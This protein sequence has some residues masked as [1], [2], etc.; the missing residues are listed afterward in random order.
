MSKSDI[1][2]QLQLVNQVQ[3]CLKITDYF[4]SFFA[5]DDKEKGQ[6]LC[7]QFKECQSHDQF[8]D[9]I[10]QKLQQ[11]KLNESSLDAWKNRCMLDLYISNQVY[12]HFNW[13]PDL[14]QELVTEMET[15]IKTQQ[16]LPANVKIMIFY[17]SDSILLPNCQ[18][19]N[20]SNEKLQNVNLCS[21]NVVENIQGYR[22]TMFNINTT[23]N[24]LYLINRILVAR[25]VLFDLINARQYIGNPAYI[26]YNPLDHKFGH[27]LLDLNTRFELSRMPP[28][29]NL[30]MKNYFD[31]YGIYHKNKDELTP[32][33]PVYI[34]FLTRNISDSKTDIT[35]YIKKLAQQIR[36][37]MHIDQNSD[38]HLIMVIHKKKGNENKKCSSEQSGIKDK[39]HHL[40]IDT[41]LLDNL[42]YNPLKN[43]YQPKFRLIKRNTEEHDAVLQHYG[44]YDAIHRMLYKDPVNKFF[45][46]EINDIYEIVR[47]QSTKINNNRYTQLHLDI[48]YR[49]VK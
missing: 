30:E 19:Y 27:F 48:C 28:E 47:P 20:L 13:N 36:K 21:L 23:T 15:K 22:K 26:Y 11:D 38:I 25:N 39:E 18:F 44:T 7:R 14:K 3:T 1:K 10:T 33:M 46:G 32:G 9:K 45:G 6:L 29:E 49:I 4:I 42:Q 43:I 2:S 16:Q 8:M 12:I 40:I 24:D 31:I 41:M 37:F 35:E 5:I 17:Q 34:H